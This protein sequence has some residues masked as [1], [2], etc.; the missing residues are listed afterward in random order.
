MM[1]PSNEGR[2]LGRRKSPKRGRVEDL[3]WARPG[4][5]V[6]AD[7]ARVRF[8]HRLLRSGSG[9][10]PSAGVDGAWS[11]ALLTWVIGVAVPYLG[12][13]RIGWLPV[14]VVAGTCLVALVGFVPA[15]W[16][17]AR[18]YREPTVE[19]AKPQG[20]TADRASNRPPLR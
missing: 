15:A 11:T 6:R 10:G 20:A 13:V 5:D 18:F 9:E 2:T 7:L 4:G 14:G 19:D 8:S 16:S 1:R 17:T 3:F 12:I